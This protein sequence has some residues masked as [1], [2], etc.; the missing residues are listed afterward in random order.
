MLG[1]MRIGVKQSLVEEAI[2]AAASTPESPVSPTQVRQA[3]MLEADLGSAVQRAFSGTLAEAR[4][5]LFHP[6][7]FIAPRS[8]VSTQPKKQSPASPELKYLGCPILRAA[9]GGM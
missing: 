9:K 3:V 5:R 7:G 8:P 6:L 4:M 1:D 2:A